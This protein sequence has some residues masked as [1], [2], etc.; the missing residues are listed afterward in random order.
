[1]SEDYDWLKQTEEMI[2]Q[3]QE[4][5]EKIEEI[6]KRIERRDG[7]KLDNNNVSS[8]ESDD[9]EYKTEKYSNG[10]YTGYFLNGIRQGTGTY[11]WSTGDWY[12]GEWEDGDITGYGKEKIGN[13]I[14]EGQFVDGKLNG[15]IT[16]TNTSGLGE[17]IYLDYEDG[18]PA[19][20]GSVY[21]VNGDTYCGALYNLKPYG[22]GKYTTNLNET[23]VGSFYAD[24]KGI[25][26]FGYE[27]DG[28]GAEFGNNVKVYYQ[29]GDSYRGAV[30]NVDL[31]SYN[32]AMVNGNIAT[33]VPNGYGTYRYASEGIACHGRW[34]NGQISQGELYYPNGDHYEGELSGTQ[35]HGKGKMYYKSNDKCEECQWSNDRATRLIRKFNASSEYAEYSTNKESDYGD[36]YDASED[37]TF[38]KNFDGSHYINYTPSKDE[39]LA[40][41]FDDSYYVNCD[42]LDD[43]PS[44]KFYD[45]T[46]DFLDSISRSQ[47]TYSS[48]PSVK[49]TPKKSSSYSSSN[50][51]SYTPYSS[52]YSWLYDDDYSSS[53]SDSDSSS[54]SNTDTSTNETTQETTSEPEVDMFAIRGEIRRGYDGKIATIG[55][56]QVSYDYLGRYDRIGDHKVNYEDS[57]SLDGTY[58]IKDIDGMPVSYDSDGKINRI[59][60]N[61][62]SY[63][64][65]GNPYISSVM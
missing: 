15:S 28:L 65:D 17:T 55:S 35:R 56:Q 27:E 48:S 8:D 64:S 16:I 62:V 60:Y 13:Y 44:K 33:F 34:T 54:S 5:S 30:K 47:P 24:E 11:T 41:D 42:D 31:S 58:R 2:K 43:S 26:K 52:Y 61:E 29:N 46:S 14:Y 9:Y 49:S 51:K 12:Q 39:I 63:D 36:F 50:N 22:H 18:V 20:E 25:L 23:C 10:E 7:I 59:G 3:L 37:E 40:K 38:A 57:I 45:N 19:S 21:Y 32:G 4:L 53:N 1:M 6:R